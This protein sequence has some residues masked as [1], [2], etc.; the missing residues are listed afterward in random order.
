MSE[1]R[2]ATLDP[3][4]FASSAFLDDA[5]VIVQNPR[6]GQFN[7]PGGA[8]TTALLAEFEDAEGKKHEQVY[9]IGDPQKFAAS[10]DGS[11]VLLT[12][13]A[14][15]IPSKSNFAEFAKSLINSGVPR[16]L[17][18]TDSISAIAGLRIHVRATPQ[19][20][21]QGNVKKND[22]GYDRTILLATAVIALPGASPK[23]A[24]APAAAKPAA[25]AKAAPAAAA[26]AP[27]SEEL[28]DKA[29]RFLSVVVRE[30]GGSMPRAKVSTAVFQ[31]AMKAKDNDKQALMKVVFEESFLTE[32]SGRPVVEGESMF[33][34]EYDAATKVITS[35]A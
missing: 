6:F 16:E 9:S 2:Y 19:K 18:Q 15:A 25:G 32:N 24:K 7:Y 4:T 22:K 17:L 21:A 28:A 20:D 1:V 33:S 3:E 10:D 11:K 23:G 34:F 14:S 5:D 29:V 12:G 13:T 30:A 27:V 35:A 8:V 31:A 26:T